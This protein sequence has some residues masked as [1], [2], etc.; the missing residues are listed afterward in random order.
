MQAHFS[1][2]VYELHDEHH[3]EK[4]STDGE[5]KWIK[6]QWHNCFPVPMKRLIKVR[7]NVQ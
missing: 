3:D 2:A 4:F 5:N 1:C 7:A 6:N